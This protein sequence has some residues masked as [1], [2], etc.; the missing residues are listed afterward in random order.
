MAVEFF[1]DGDDVGRLVARIEVAD[2]GEDQ[3]V[4]A[5]VE[6]LRLERVG[7]ADQALGI[8]QQAAQGCALGFDVLRGKAI[9]NQGDVPPGCLELFGGGGVLFVDELGVVVA[10]ERGFRGVVARKYGLAMWHKVS[11]LFD[12]LPIAAVRA[13][14]AIL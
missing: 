5:T 10:T 14:G 2:G 1:A 6:I 9:L 11:A 7:D 8:D 3:L 4:G 13:G 12:E